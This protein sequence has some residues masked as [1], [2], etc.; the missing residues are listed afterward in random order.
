MP[1]SG[2]ALHARE[3]AETGGS[4]GAYRWI[5]FAGFCGASKL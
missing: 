4:A 3:I 1:C 2:H 5:G